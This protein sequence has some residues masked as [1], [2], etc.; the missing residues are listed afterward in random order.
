MPLTTGSGSNFVAADD[1]TATYSR[2][3]GENGSPPTYHITATLSATPLAARWT[4]TSSPTTGR[5]SRSTSG[6]ATWTTNAASKTYGDADPVPLTTGSGSNF[7]AADNVT[8]TYSRVAGETPARRPYHIT[9]T[10]AAPLA[11][12]LDNYIITNA[13]ADFTI[14]K[15]AATWTTNA[16]T[17]TYGD[18]D[19]V[20]LTTGSGSN[21]VAADNVTATYSRVG[22]ETVAGSPYLITATLAAPVAGVLDNYTITNAGADF[23]ITQRA[24]SVTPASKMKVYGNVDPTLTGTLSGFLGSD[25][26]TATYSRTAGESVAGSPYT[27]SGTLAP[28]GALGN[29]AITYNTAAFTITLRPATWNTNDNSKIL[30]APDPNPLTT[31]AAAPVGPGTGFLPTDLVTATYTRASGE[32]VAGN[33]YHITATLSS[34]AAALGNYTITNDGADFFIQFLWTGFLQ[35]INDTAHQTGTTQSKF[36]TGQTIPAKFVLKNASGVAVTQ[37]PNPAFTRSANRGSCETAA[38]PENTEPLPADVVPVYKLTGAEYHYNWST[39]GLSSG[40]YR[41]Y[42]NLADGTTPW[43]D[44]CLTK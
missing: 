41:I 38:T 12:A 29:Y 44:I 22:G 3:A 39:K 36:K 25:G 33:P 37:T 6:L 35:P 20:P 27:I 18:A 11:A 26:V 21:F 23:T 8:A 17:K 5:T 30:G 4:T 28:V 13:G 7:V 40:V 43:V 15:R 32:T 19:P 31:G 1:V 2:V 10:L 14:N 9:A 24:A 42:A 16:A 34:G